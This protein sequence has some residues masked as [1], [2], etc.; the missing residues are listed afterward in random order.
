MHIGLKCACIAA[1]LAVS[2]SA[3]AQQMVFLDFDSGNSG[4]INYTPA[5]RAQVQSIMETQWSMFDVSFTQ[6]APGGQFSTLTFNAG[7]P[8]GLAEH[9]DFRNL[10]H[11]DTAVINVDGLGIAPSNY[12][13]STANIGSHELGHLLGIRHRDSFGPIGSGS[14]G[15]IGAG[16]FLPD[17]PG[18]IGADET[19]SHIMATPAFGTP[20]SN[21]FTPNWLSERSAIKMQF[22]QTGTVV[23]ESGGANDSIA[24]AQPLALGNMTVPNTIVTGD[25]A[26]IGDFSV[27]AIT[28]TAELSSGDAQD[29]YSFTASAGDLMNFEV[30]SNVLDQRIGNTIDSMISILDSNG[31]FVDY[32]GTDA[33]NDDEIETTDSLILDLIIPADGTYYVMVEPFSNGDTGGYE[34]FIN[35]F[36]GAVPAPASAAFFAMGGLIASRRR[37]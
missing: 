28:V 17:Y 22:S 24:T 2:A 34:L 16:P 19:D 26:G 5:M 3:A 32:Y 35:R 4:N 18:P 23:A 33:T 10:D 12:V 9:I 14:Y 37:R 7:G 25:N 1:G 30:M 6:T 29:F 36:N 20:L 11:S 8:G 27:D 21:I 15:P 31:D 13:A